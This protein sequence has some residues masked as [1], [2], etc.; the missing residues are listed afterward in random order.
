MTD[1]EYVTIAVPRLTAER[2]QRMVAEKQSGQIIINLNHGDPQS[3][4]IKEHYR[5]TS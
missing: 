5:I 4:E 1:R 2:Y 3:F